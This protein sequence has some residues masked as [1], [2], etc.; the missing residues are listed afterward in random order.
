MMTIRTTTLAVCTVLCHV[1]VLTAQGQTRFI[2]FLDGDAPTR[3]NVLNELKRAGPA[4]LDLN[5]LKLT[6][7]ASL[8]DSAA[9][10]RRHGCYV[11]YGRALR[12]SSDTALQRGAVPASF[13]AEQQMLVSLSSDVEA[14]LADEVTAV[15]EACVSAIS[16]LGMEGPYGP[17]RHLGTATAKILV[18]RYDVE[19]DGA[20]RGALIHGL[21]RGRV[22]DVA[23]VRSALLRA[24]QDANGYARQMARIGV[25]EYRLTEAIPNLIAGL[26]DALASTRLDSARALA[27]IGSAAR[28]HVDVV[29]QR[30]RDERDPVVRTELQRAVV[31]LSANAR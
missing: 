14:G 15:R 16:A 5:D 25:G 31:A 17:Q 10:V 3:L 22:D 18:H 12:V 6:L 24:L 11:V 29:K 28:A 30:L 23:L 27:Q 26:D 21:A 19:P 8:K 2:R 13:G 20:I 7:Q 4:T 9:E 1:G